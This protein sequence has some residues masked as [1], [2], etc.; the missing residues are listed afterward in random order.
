MRGL[1]RVVLLV[2]LWLLAW[3][4]VSPANVVTGVALVGVLLVA[5]PVE[6]TT[7][8]RARPRPLALARLGAY[9]VGNLIVS[10][11]LVARQVVARRAR[12]NTGV[13]EYDPHYPTDLVM[14]V[15]ANIIAL[16]PGTM[17]V[18]VTQEPPLLRVHFLMLEDEESAR[19]SITRLERLVAAAT[20]A[21][22]PSTSTKAAR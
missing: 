20:G 11:V 5:F 18:D 7:R 12:I 14:A 9:I 21:D 2:A 4:E 10:N 8:V 16:T 1:A 6:R 19:R 13:I 3:G 17:T 22:E 15:V